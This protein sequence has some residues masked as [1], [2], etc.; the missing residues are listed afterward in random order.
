MRRK[1]ADNAAKGMFGDAG[2]AWEEYE[3]AA[4][5]DG[6]VFKIGLID[7]MRIYRPF[8]DAVRGKIHLSYQAGDHA[9]AALGAMQEGLGKYVVQQM[10]L[11]FKH[12]CERARDDAQAEHRKELK[13]ALEEREREVRA[14]LAGNNVVGLPV[15]RGHVL[16]AIRKVRDDVFNNEDIHGYEA[17]DDVER[18]VMSLFRK[19]S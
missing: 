16:A 2:V 12:G 6:R 15:L 9:A 5:A 11:A 7:E 3:G 17:V 13:A 4:P 18:V 14:E 1:E 19:C 8:G 10:D